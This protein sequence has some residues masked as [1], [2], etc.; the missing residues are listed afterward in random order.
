MRETQPRKIDMDKALEIATEP[1]RALEPSMP[2]NL[3]GYKPTEQF[4]AP[5]ITAAE[6]AFEERELEKERS[7]GDIMSSRW[8]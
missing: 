8:S 5:L 2:E 4:Q 6:A 3:P 7:I 1:I